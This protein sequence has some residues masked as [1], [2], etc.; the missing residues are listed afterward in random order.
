MLSG[1]INLTHQFEYKLDSRTVGQPIKFVAEATPLVLA[2]V[3]ADLSAV[4]SILAIPAGAETVNT[5]FYGKPPLAYALLQA[6]NFS[7]TGQI[8]KALLEQKKTNKNHPFVKEPLKKLFFN[9]V[10]QFDLDSVNFCLTVHPEC[11]NETNEQGKTPLAHAIENYPTL[12]EKMKDVIELFIKQKADKNNHSVKAALKEKFMNAIKQGNIAFVNYFLELDPTL[13]NAEDKDHLTPLAYAFQHTKNTDD[14][15]MIIILSLIEH[16][17]NIQ[18]PSIKQYTKDIKDEDIRIILK[19]PKPLNQLSSGDKAFYQFRLASYYDWL[20][21]KIKVENHFAEKQLCLNLLAAQNGH[22]A[23]MLATVEGYSYSWYELAK[24]HLKSLKGLS[25]NELQSANIGDILLH[26]SQKPFGLFQKTDLSSQNQTIYWLEKQY[27]LRDAGSIFTTLKNLEDKSQSSL[28]QLKAVMTKSRLYVTRDK[29]RCLT[30][31]GFSVLKCLEEL[32]KGRELF[33]KNSDNNEFKKEAIIELLKIK[34]ELLKEKTTV[35]NALYHYKQAADMGDLYAAEQG[36]EIA[37]L[38]KDDES[39]HAFYNQAI[40]NAQQWNYHELAARLKTEQPK[41][42]ERKE[43][44]LAELKV[45]EQPTEINIVGLFDELETILITNKI[46]TELSTINSLPDLLTKFQ[47]MNQSEL[48]LQLMI[49]KAEQLMKASLDVNLLFSNNPPAFALRHHLIKTARILLLERGEA[50]LAQLAELSNQECFADVSELRVKEEE[51]QI[52]LEETACLYEKLLAANL[53]VKKLKEAEHNAKK[54]LAIQTEL[55]KNQKTE[56][57]AE[58]KKEDDLFSKLQTAKLEN[59]LDE[60]FPK[61]AIARKSEIINFIQLF[62]KVLNE[63]K[64]HEKH[65]QKNHFVR[66]IIPQLINHPFFAELIPVFFEKNPALSEFR[67]E[68]IS[69]TIKQLVAMNSLSSD[70][71]IGKIIWERCFTDHTAL[72]I[73]TPLEFDQACREQVKLFSKC[74]SESKN[75][76]TQKEALAKLKELASLPMIDPQLKITIQRKILNFEYSQYSKKPHEK[77]ELHKETLSRFAKE[78]SFEAICQLDTIFASEKNWKGNPKIGRRLALCALAMIIKDKT[79]VDNQLIIREKLA[80]LNSKFM[81]KEHL[82][83]ARWYLDLIEKIIPSLTISSSFNDRLNQLLQTDPVA[84]L[85]KAAE[86]CV[87]GYRKDEAESI[88]KQVKEDL[89]VAFSDKKFIANKVAIANATRTPTPEPEAKAASPATDTAGMLRKL[90]TAASIYPQLDSRPPAYAPGWNDGSNADDLDFQVLTRD[91]HSK[92]VPTLEAKFLTPPA[93]YAPQQFRPT[94]P[95]VT[96]VDIDLRDLYIAALDGF[97]VPTLRDPRCRVALLK[98][99]NSSVDQKSPSYSCKVMANFYLLL[100][101]KVIP[102]VQQSLDG[103]KFDPAIKKA[104]REENYLTFLQLVSVPAWINWY[105]QQF[106]VSFDPLLISTAINRGHEMTSMQAAP[107]TRAH[108]A[109]SSESDS[110]IFAS[111]PPFCMDN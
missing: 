45:A 42:A 7:G 10:Q 4:K 12:D 32:K 44:S 8:V 50:G 102:L 47:D 30:N 101:E 62:F 53:E 71:D 99:S 78:N 41:E 21:S 82:L 90:P 57:K 110:V 87:E 23:S 103:D 88:K 91:E 65:I 106:N 51:R 100:I 22:E 95:K 40:T 74:M 104:F 43:N 80:F 31:K 75:K 35:K 49:P 28:I 24:S 36:I 70:L 81:K 9:A 97:L 60:Y 16:N 64:A 26:V 93:V 27:F 20:A 63:K 37:K 18:H 15:W 33:Q 58:D 11:V 107:A 25:E 14:N 3:L 1:T 6:T 61:R 66:V 68:I 85:I 17:A 111:A 105:Q 108:A 2:C 5:E 92:S 109:A 46:N 39:V 48:A 83:L 86:T 67:N 59:E 73:Q 38:I 69:E 76:G 96:Q 72:K 89:A 19:M 52:K 55:K 29:S 84:F 94:A 77:I 54:L 79:E 56:S 13:V 34:A 98:W